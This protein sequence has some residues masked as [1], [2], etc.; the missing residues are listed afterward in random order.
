VIY[1]SLVKKKGAPSAL[2]FFIVALRTTDGQSSYFDFIFPQLINSVFGPHSQDPSGLITSRDPDA[3]NLNIGPH[4]ATSIVP[5]NELG[6][7]TTLN[8]EQ[9]DDDPLAK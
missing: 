7:G 8:V 1:S 9:E 3:S 4:V 5:V 2:P 6:S